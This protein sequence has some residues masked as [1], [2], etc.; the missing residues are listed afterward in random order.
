M[1]KIK[2]HFFGYF[3]I[4]ITFIIIFSN[5]KRMKE[6]WT[7]PKV[8]FVPLAPAICTAGLPGLGTAQAKL[9][10]DLKLKYDLTIG[11]P[12][13]AAGKTYAPSWGP[14]DSEWKTDGG[15]G[16][17]AGG[18]KDFEASWDNEGTGHTNI[19][20]DGTYDWP[21]QAGDAPVEG[22]NYNF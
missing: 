6:A 5:G 4:F 8:C 15:A 12:P 1:F 9:V 20:I 19:E 11:G 16:T 14:D 18:G 7:V 22:G 10:K 21:V 2:N 3:I 17:G 13:I